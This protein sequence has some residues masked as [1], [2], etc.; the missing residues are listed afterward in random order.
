MTTTYTIHSFSK[1]ILLIMLLL[2]TLLV[3]QE[4]Q[5]RKPL[6]AGAQAPAIRYDLSYPKDYIIAPKK[7]ILLDFW[8]TWCGPCIAGLVELNPVIPK[9]KDKI[10]FLAI[11]DSTSRGV[12]QFIQGKDFNYT[13][14]INKD[15]SVFESFGVSGIPHAFLI[16]ENNII[17]WSG[18]SRGLSPDMLEEFL[19]SGS[20]RPRQLSSS[21]DKNRYKDVPKSADIF[22]LSVLDQRK[23][24]Q[25]K[26]M[27]ISKVSKSDP[28]AGG[29][30]FSSAPEWEGSLTAVNF[31]LK[32][33]AERTAGYFPYLTLVVEDDDIQGYDFYAVPFDDFDTMNK[34]LEEVY[35]IKFVKK[36]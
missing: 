35:G 13:F 6:A 21:F 2:P 1:T 34:N 18:S 29:G 22:I 28:R 14:L 27:S 33:L 17:Q 16:D 8:A 20:I 12:E 36:K 5:K 30:I 11:T 32:R 24:D 9:F 10:E 31:N 15:E 23:L 7:A 4:S 19:A 3:G 26:T 25:H